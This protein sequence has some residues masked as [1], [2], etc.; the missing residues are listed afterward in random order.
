MLNP[1]KRLLDKELV[2]AEF[3]I[4][5]LRNLDFKVQELHIQK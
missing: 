1:G 2:F 4:N 3:R 5:S